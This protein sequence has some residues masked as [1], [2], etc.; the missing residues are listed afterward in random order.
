MKRKYVVSAEIVKK[1]KKPDKSERRK[2]LV[3]NVCF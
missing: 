2:P 3:A 1:K